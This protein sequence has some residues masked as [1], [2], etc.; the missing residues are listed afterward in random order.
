MTENNAE[1]RFCSKSEYARLRSWSLSF[2]SYLAQKGVLVVVHGGRYGLVDVQASDQ[3][4]G[5][6]IRPRF[7]AWQDY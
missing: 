4:Y 1:P 5:D 6:M 3:N 7:H 2:V